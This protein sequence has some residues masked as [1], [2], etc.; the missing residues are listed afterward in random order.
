MSGAQS[1]AAVAVRGVFSTLLLIVG[2]L[3]LLFGIFLAFEA[4][5]IT[6]TALVDFLIGAVLIVVSGWV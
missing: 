5:A 3:V 6:W 1:N 2:I 4:Q